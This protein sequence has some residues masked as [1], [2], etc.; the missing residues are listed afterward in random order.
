M[1]YDVLA[2]LMRF[3]GWWGRMRVEGLEH[4]P[5][6][7]AV[8]LAPNHDSQMDPVLISVAARPR[9]RLRYLAGDDL[10][11]IPL[12]GPILDGMRQI[13]IKRGAGDSRALEHA[14]EALNAGD[15][16]TVFPEGRLSWGQRLR[17]RSGL[18]LLAG[19]VPEA[20]IVLCAIT[21]STDFVR[22]PARPRVTVTFFPPATGGI[23]PGEEPAAFSARMLK[24][25][26]ERAPITPAGRRRIIG[27]P[28]RVRR[29]L[30]RNKTLNELPPEDD[31]AGTPGAQ[32]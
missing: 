5:A 2:Q 29:V 14:V 27:G 6:S 32:A 11:R 22:F 4:L 19:W 16:V 30:E 26:R 8:L 20:S 23:R 10:W 12:L 1:L 9:R 24:E 25:L 21:G 18:G 15:V 13:P 7:G 28:P 17:A 3:L 31:G